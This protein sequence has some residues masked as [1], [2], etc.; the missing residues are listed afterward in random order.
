MADDPGDGVAGVQAR[1]G[2]HRVARADDQRAAQPHEIGAQACKAFCS[3][4][5]LPRRGVGQS[6]VVRLDDME[7]HNRPALPDRMSQGG[8]I[9]HAQVALEP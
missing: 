5:V 9:L 4:T 1:E 3:E 6:P 2:L 8:M 7:R